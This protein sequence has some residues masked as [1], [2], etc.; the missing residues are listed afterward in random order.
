MMSPGKHTLIFSARTKTH[1]HARI[2]KMIKDICK[3][4]AGILMEDILESDS[5]LFSK[6]QTLAAH[7]T[8]DTGNIYV[9]IL[10]SV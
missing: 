10:D 6:D 5:G 8:L 4:K 1:T 7:G 2:N 3:W 9:C